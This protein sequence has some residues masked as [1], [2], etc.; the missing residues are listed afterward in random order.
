LE[1]H[2]T[3]SSVS[4]LPPSALSQAFNQSEEILTLGITVD[5]TGSLVP[6]LHEQHQQLQRPP[7]QQTRAQISQ[8][9]KQQLQYLQ[10][11]ADLQQQRYS[12][13][14]Y[15]MSNHSLSTETF[16]FPFR[17]I[18][19]T[20]QPQTAAQPSLQPI[21]MPPPLRIPSNTSLSTASSYQDNSSSVVSPTMIPY[22]Y[23]TKV[24]STSN[25]SSKKRK[26]E[27]KRYND[28]K[29][30]F[31]LLMKEEKPVD[32]RQQP[33]PQPQPQPQQSPAPSSPERILDLWIDR[34][35][36]TL[37]ISNL[38]ELYTFLSLIC[39]PSITFYINASIIP[40]S[41]G[42]L[43]IKTN[44]HGLFLFWSLLR[45]LHQQCKMKIIEKRIVRMSSPRAT[46]PSSL[47]IRP[48]SRFGSSSPS[49]PS[50]IITVEYI[51]KL[52]GTLLSLK[53]LQE[54]FN[55][56]YLMG[57]FDIPFISQYYSPISITSNVTTSD[58]PLPFSSHPPG[59]SRSS[60]C[61]SA[62]IPL[63]SSS[64]SHA[65]S[66]PLLP[67]STHSSPSGYLRHHP[68]N[69]HST[70]EDYTRSINQY[71]QQLQQQERTFGISSSSSSSTLLNPFRRRSDPG[72]SLSDNSISPEDTA[73]NDQF[74][75]VNT[76]VTHYLSNQMKQPLGSYT[77][78]DYIFELR[79]DFNTQLKKVVG[80]KIDLLAVK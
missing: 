74:S 40:F 5:P 54:T 1:G 12:L 8:E 70:V 71:H 21:S 80:W 26:K 55:D 64:S 59:I 16:P 66:P 33:P 6:T 75:F 45:L 9:D 63:L 24:D 61:P 14:D 20:S 28:V 36:S 58:S 2:S 37:L 69:N 65:P 34:F 77:N 67:M 3:A 31:G 44:F 15:P 49:S 51:T 48:S 78:Y 38:T 43:T 17:Q 57:I 73:S 11:Q 4:E 62:F 29:H 56:F 13:P 42:G 22:P 53:T 76:I 46:T 52:S 47:G 39:H 27:E 35:I 19:G 23:S 18:S 50:G 60:S 25:G 68:Y 30:S 7:Y 32:N 41:V 72:R 79:V 10:W